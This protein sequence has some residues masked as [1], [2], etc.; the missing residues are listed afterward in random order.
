MSRNQETVE[1]FRGR[2]FS[3]HAPPL[4]TPTLWE[5]KDHRYPENVLLSLK[6]VPLE[7]NF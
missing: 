5:R 1:G 7:E 3:R 4:G 6:L 2:P